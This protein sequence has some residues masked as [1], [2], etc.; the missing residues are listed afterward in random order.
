MKRIVAVLTLTLVGCSTSGRVLPPADD[1]TPGAAQPSSD[2][3]AVEVFPRTVGEDGMGVFAADFEPGGQIPLTHHLEFGATPIEIEWTD[4]D[5]TAVELAVV[6][7]DVDNASFVHWVIV[8]IDPGREFLDANPLPPGA[9][10]MRNDTGAVGFLGLSPPDGVT[11][12]YQVWFYA[13]PSPFPL[14]PITTEPIDARIW[15]DQNALSIATVMGSMTGPPCSEV[16]GSDSP[17]CDNGGT[18]ATL[19]SPGVTVEDHD[20]P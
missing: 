5:P 14:D 6:V 9:V 7:L 16:Y 19:P 2:P 1:P 15:L 12:R 13:L 18:A 10:E 11:H 20:G 17:S 8:G 3:T 4:L